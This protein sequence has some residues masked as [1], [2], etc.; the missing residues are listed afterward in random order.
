V[1]KLCLILTFI[2]SIWSGCAYFNTF[3][4][5]SQFYHQAEIEISAI[6]E[7][8]ENK[9]SDNALDL[10]NKT[11]IR[12]NKVLNDHPDSDF[13]DDAL[14][15]K[16][17]AL[18]HLGQISAA[19]STIRFLESEFPES[20]LL[21][22]AN[23]WK[24]RC[25]WK[26]GMENYALLK[27]LT[28]IANLDKEEKPKNYKKLKS[29]GHKTASEI[30]E[31]E[32]NV[33]SS[34]VHLERAANIA[35]NR[36]ERAS[37][38]YLIAE[39]AYNEKK[40]AVALQNY[41]KVVSFHPNPKHIETAHLQIVR[42][43]RE[44]EEWE[45]ASIEIEDLTI[46]D[47]FSRIKADLMLELAKLY[48]IQGRKEEAVNRYQLITEEFPRTRASAE[49]YYKM[50]SFT[51]QKEQNYSEAR[52]YFDNVEKEFRQS[53]FAPSAKVRVREI[54]DLILDI[55]VI[56]ELDERLFGINSDNSV[57]NDKKLYD[58]LIQNTEN[59]QD[60]TP[61]IAT[62]DISANLDSSLLFEQMAI[63]LY[64]A[65]ELEAF[66]FGH[67]NTG[68]NYFKRI[69]NELPITKRTAQA[70]Y[71][72]SY[73]HKTKGDSVTSEK[74]NLILL[75]SFSNS[76]F[77]H[78]IANEKKLSIVDVPAEMMIISESFI[79]SKPDSAIMLYEKILTEYPNTRYAPIVLLSIAHIY[80][81][82]LNKLPEAKVAYER[83]AKTYS[84]SDH[85]DFA[86]ER[87][88]IFDRILSS[89]EEK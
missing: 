52:K 82:R 21:L 45:L 7:I 71:S 63:H 5:A 57:S 50:G 23:L 70:I 12:C 48:E 86:N 61:Q 62:T 31:E 42:I 56:Q 38:H 83:L 72:L 36:I 87:I 81:R 85:A 53:T 75:E 55:K 4:N 76:E 25:E 78:D 15:L 64:S 74:L 67:I 47:K 27:T 13:R 1:K 49:S 69:V 46:T 39:K 43:Y 88:A 14:L 6:S 19:L 10:L 79:E 17:K 44:M 30:Y 89:I 2:F 32:G 68:M 41:R 80:D 24:I 18:Y 65:G 58:D 66:R 29:F 26:G 34:L 59:I 84:K 22:E 35:D 77:A 3:Y 51:L 54:D 8:S 28:F 37:A 20:Q 73:L 33:D 40:L 16:S 60:D 9:L 11:I